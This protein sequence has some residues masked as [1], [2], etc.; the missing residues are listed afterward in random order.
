MRTGGGGGTRQREPPAGSPLFFS[1]FTSAH[2][3]SAAIIFGEDIESLD[4][5]LLHSGRACP[6]FFYLFQP[7]SRKGWPK[8]TRTEEISVFA[9]EVDIQRGRGMKSRATERNVRY[10]MNGHRLLHADSRCIRPVE[11]ERRL[12]TVHRSDSFFPRPRNRRSCHSRETLFDFPPIIA[13]RIT[14]YCI[15]HIRL[16][17]SM[18]NSKQLSLC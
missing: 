18:L 10:R 8:V 11:T 5:L 7:R 2:F 13:E 16:T 3:L 6:S 17:E 1:F 9:C 14:T 4:D 12:T 15:I